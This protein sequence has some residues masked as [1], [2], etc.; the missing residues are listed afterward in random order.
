MTLS[1]LDFGVVSNIAQGLWRRVEST[2]VMQVESVP[3]VA[4]AA[5]QLDCDFIFQRFRKGEAP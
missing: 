2:Q 3:Q 1:V 4:G 5:S